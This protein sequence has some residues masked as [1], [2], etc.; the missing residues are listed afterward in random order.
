MSETLHRGLRLTLASLL[1]V[2]LFA[3]LAIG[4]SR[5]ALSVVNFLSFFA[6][7]SNAAAVVLLVLLAV[8]PGRY[9]SPSF[10]VFRG[11]VTVYMSVTG[12]IYAV[13]LAPVAAEVGVAEPWIE[14]SI[15]ALGPIAIALDW[16]VY[17]P[18]TRL[19]RSAIPIWLVFPAVYLGFTLVRGVIV[20]WYPYPFLDPATGGYEAVALWSAVALVVILVFGFGYHWW[21]NR[22]RVSAPA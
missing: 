14:W 10:A 6:V 19:P 12:L 4:M 5:S 2:A 16:I 13:F 9:D 11:A 18:S 8:R 1:M 7:L 17:P 3:Q 15:H 22:E 20:D 21:S